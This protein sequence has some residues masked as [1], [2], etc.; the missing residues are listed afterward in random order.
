MRCSM[1]MSI[2][3]ATRCWIT[4]RPCSPSSN[5]RRCT[6][7]RCSTCGTA[8]RSRTSARRR[9][10]SRAWMGFRRRPSGSTSRPAARRWASRAARCD[11]AGTTSFQRRAPMSAR[12][13]S[14]ATTSPT[15]ATSSSS[16]QGAIVNGNGGGRKTGNGCSASGSRIRRSGNSTTAHGSG[17]ACS[18]WC[19]CRRRGRCMSARPKRRRM[20]AGA[21]RGCRPKPNS[22]ARH[23]D[24]RI[25]NGSIHGEM[26][27]PTRA[28][29]CS[30]SR[31]G[32]LNRPA[33]IPPARARGASR[34]SSATAGNGP[35]RR[36]HRFR[37]SRRWHRI[38]NT[39]PTFST[40]STWSSKER[41]WRRRRS[42]CGR[43]SA[44]GFAAAIPTCMQPSAAQNKNTAHAEAPIGSLAGDVRYY[45]TL[46]PRQLPSRYLYDP[47]GSA[48]FEA[49][50]ELPW[51]RI[52]KAER[53]LLAAHG[54]EILAQADPLSMLVELGPGSGEKLA[55]VV[56]AAGARA[57]ALT[58]HLVD[59]SAAALDHA[60]RTIAA[61]DAPNLLV[62]P[63]QAT[64]E[65]GLLEAMAVRSR[66]GHAL[67]LF[68]GSNIG[69]FDPPGAA[70]F[71]VGMRA[72]LAAGDALLIGTDLV[73][74]EDELLRA[75]DDPLGVTAAFN[76][77]LLVRINRDLDADFDIDAFGHRALWNAEESR[78]EMH[79]VATKA[80]RV[81]IPGASLEVAFEQGETI[82][83]ES[84]YKF[85][86]DA[87][88]RLLDRA[89][90]RRVDQWIDTAAGFALTLARAV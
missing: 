12:S 54:R 55:A 34:I 82:W 56:T 61:L 74:P 80:Q 5:T 85:E 76:R 64:Y 73:K 6:R 70:A 13:R 87:V 37:D 9:D 3:P 72:A 48:L 28:A 68:L 78:V 11:S 30:I 38:R 88:V 14:S 22:S 20:R 21:A 86:P 51:Y 42:C 63:H 23:T 24:R 32:I 62:V 33:A 40:A 25:R 77:N 19:R 83:T 67:A 66:H 18:S 50:C 17:A 35:A 59:V 7:K 57:R 46:T 2:A 69:N 39:P 8:C 53:R 15:H 27:S 44:T 26:R 79:L 16:T 75:Y 4:P 29:A 58:I 81:R 90:F 71:L 1:P 45:L 84:S 47:L 10:I 52:T 31:A 60:G 65:S 89:G 36:S 41:R 43:R 49:I